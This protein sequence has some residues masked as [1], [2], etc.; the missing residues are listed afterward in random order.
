MKALLLSLL[1]S[2]STITPKS[3]DT[4]VIKNKDIEVKKHSKGAK[5]KIFTHDAFVK[6]TKLFMAE[7]TIPKAGKVPEHRDAADEYLYVV[8]GNGIIWIDG[9][10]FNVAENDFIYMPAMSKVE[11]ENSEDNEFKVFQIFAPAGPEE[12]YNNW[13]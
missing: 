1:V 2:C 4:K 3:F 8:K 9:E 11:F 13:K 5:V 12:K 7:L 10:K 6:R